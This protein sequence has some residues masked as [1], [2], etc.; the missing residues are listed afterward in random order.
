MCAAR[1]STVQRSH[2]AATSPQR[3]PCRTAT[4]VKLDVRVDEGGHLTFVP[5]HA[6]RA[7]ASLTCLPAGLQLTGRRTSTALLTWDD[8]ERID[9]DLE[10]A[11]DPGCWSISGWG[12]SRYGENGSIGVGVRCDPS[13]GDDVRQ[14]YTECQTLWRRVKWASEPSRK[15]L[16]V[17]PRS[18]IFIPHFGE[19][20]TLRILADVLHTHE[21]LRSRLDDGERTGRLADCLR[22]QWLED[23]IP[24]TGA[25][26]D[27]TD[28][29]TA[30]R[31][32][33]FVHPFGRPL[34]TTGLPTVEEVADRV[35]ELLRAN[36]YRAGR[37]NDR[38]QIEA[39]VRRDYTD[40]KPW[41]FAALVDD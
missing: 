25:G 27:S 34:T 6:R 2:V 10:N 11:I 41:P 23:P 26:R 4:G 22:A 40:V 18:V 38:A 24:R 7:L 19:L 28:I 15:A 9:L 31:Q 36:P 21:R 33:G 35:E 14:L 32:G 13:Y 29:H 8:F 37:T 12:R 16:P 39:I 30:L 20:A 5:V 17:L 3:L 1:T